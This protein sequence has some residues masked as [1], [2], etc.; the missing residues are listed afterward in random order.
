MSGVPVVISRTHSRNRETF[1]TCGRGGVLHQPPK[2]VHLFFRF[3]PGKESQN[4]KARQT[5]HDCRN[6]HIDF[7]HVNHDLPPTLR[8]MRVSP[9][10]QS[11]PVL[12]PMELRERSPARSTRSS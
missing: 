6:Q 1:A 9:H 5:K 8:G 11:M 7:K 2:T 4:E 10:L 12:P 3:L